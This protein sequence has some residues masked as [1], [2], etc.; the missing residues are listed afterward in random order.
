MTEQE[1]NNHIKTLRDKG[2][3][4][5]EIA[6]IFGKMF[7]DGKI[8]REILEGFLEGIGLELSPEMTKL[9]DEEL[10]KVM[11]ADK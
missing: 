3:V 1:F 2:Y 5:T 8:T 4:D 11:T 7:I 9:S 6:Q 10:K